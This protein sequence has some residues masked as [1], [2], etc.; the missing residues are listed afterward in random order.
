M[1]TPGRKGFYTS[2]QSASQQVAIVVAAA[3]GYGINKWLSAGDIAGWG[4]RIPFFIGCMI[5]PFI[6]FL[7]R[8]L[9]ETEEFKA[10][11]HRPS[12]GE[13][14]RTMLQN[15]K[16]VVAGMLL[17]A[18]TT[19][20]FYL[21]TVYTPTFGKSVLHL[22]TAE[23]L[24]VT[25]FVGLSNF[26]WLPVG[27]AL[28]DRIG[29]PAIMIAITLLT[30]CTAY[31]ALSWLAAAPSFGRM[32]LVLLWFSFFFGMYNGA[33]MAALTEV[34]PEKIRVAG[35]SLAFS[36]A[37]AFFGGFTP[38][39]STYLIQLTGD[40]AAPGYWLTF[41]ALCGLS[42]TCVLYRGGARKHETAPEAVVLARRP[43]V[44]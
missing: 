33:T 18:M 32:L 29:R 42:A 36:L 28:S 24:V 9:T 26:F 7:R 14:Y 38:A 2:W 20:T 22:S 43:T 40:K 6:F 35:F 25:L 5:V 16:T 23:S 11:T 12:A 44:R 41:A 15:W 13:V 31:P 4:W 3:L 34:M 17:V 27:G 8:S 1:A 39:V 30:I 37:T 19:T 10:R 21:I